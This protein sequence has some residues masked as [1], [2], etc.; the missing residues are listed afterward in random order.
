MKI[1]HADSRVVDDI[2]RT[3]EQEFGKEAPLTIQRGKVHDYLGMTLDFT[4]PGKVTIRM[5]DYIKNMLAELPEDM[6]GMATTPAAEHLFKVNEAPTYLNEKEAMFFHHN[7]A[8]LLFLCK[9]ARP[10]IQTAVAFLSTRVKQPDCDDNKKLG[11]VMRYLRKTITLTPT[12]EAN[13]LR[14]IQWWIDVAYATHRDMRSHTGGAMTLG[15]EVIYGTS[16]R[17]KLNTQSCT[18]AELVAVDDCMSHVLWTG[19]FLEAQGYDINDCIIH[20]DNKS[21]ILFEQNG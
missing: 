11:R 12:L 20:Q 15:K 9:R 6:D 5:E 17:Q 14:L 10:D 7:V 1:S 19:Y 8:K 21:A 18:K 4:N 13:K 3:L 16:T 2:I